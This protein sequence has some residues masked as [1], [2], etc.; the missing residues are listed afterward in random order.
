MILNFLPVNCVCAKPVFYF[1]LEI[2]WAQNHEE[3]HRL[4]I[5]NNFLNLIDFFTQKLRSDIFTR[6]YNSSLVIGFSIIIFFN[7]FTLHTSR[8]KSLPLEIDLKVCD[9]D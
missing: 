6:L 1:S 4:Q 3:I 8:Y 2:K 9:I 7:P 5:I